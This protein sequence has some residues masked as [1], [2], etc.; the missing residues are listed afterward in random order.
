MTALRPRALWLR[1]VDRDK[2]GLLRQPVWTLWAVVSGL[3]TVATLL[4]VNRVWVPLI[5]WHRIISGPA[6]WS[7]LI[8]PPLM[9]AVILIVIHRKVAAR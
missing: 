5:G 1:G 7:S 6:L 2:V 8:L 9:F 4:R 3:W